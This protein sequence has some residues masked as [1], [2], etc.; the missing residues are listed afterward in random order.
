MYGRMSVFYFGILIKKFITLVFTFI[1]EIPRDALTNYDEYYILV[2]CFSTRTI[3]LSIKPSSR[4]RRGE[5]L[6]SRLVG[7]RENVD[8]FSV[9]FDITY[10]PGSLL[11]L[12][13]F[14][15]IAVYYPSIITQ[16]RYR[17]CFFL[18]ISGKLL[19]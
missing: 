1:Y 3:P 16:Y 2:H 5:H 17:C 9:K 10:G 15:R 4:R 8:D 6:F 12:Y 13:L 7:F 14:L 18:G 11:S 19:Y